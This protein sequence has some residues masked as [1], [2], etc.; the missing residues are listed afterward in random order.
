M[1]PQAIDSRFNI[2]S[3]WKVPSFTMPEHRELHDI[4][5]LQCIEGHLISLGCHSDFAS[6]RNA[7]L[8]SNQNLGVTSLPASVPSRGK[9]IFAGWVYMKRGY[10]ASPGRS[11]YD[12]KGH[13]RVFEGMCVLEVIEAENIMRCTD[14]RLA[15]A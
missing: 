8:V 15:G 2:R 11:R 10:D 6:R 5:P 1:M 3:S 14:S 9:H 12:Q 7:Y 4:S 13:S